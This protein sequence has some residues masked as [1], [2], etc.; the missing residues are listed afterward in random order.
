[1]LIASG[2]CLELGLDVNAAEQF[3]VPSLP[4]SRQTSADAIRLSNRLLLEHLRRRRWFQEFGDMK[5]GV[6]YRIY[7]CSRGSV[8]F[9]YIVGQPLGLAWT[10]FLILVNRPMQFLTRW[11]KTPLLCR[12]CGKHWMLN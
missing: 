5:S 7:V 3:G 6:D 12:G 8:I 9:G 1:V 2:S 10:L 11:T 4:R